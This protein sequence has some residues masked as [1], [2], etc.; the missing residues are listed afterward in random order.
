[1]KTRRN[2][3]ARL[4][5]A[6]TLLAMT[7]LAT[8]QSDPSRPPAAQVPDSGPY[9]NTVQLFDDSEQQQLLERRQQER[10]QLRRQLAD[11]AQ[12]IE[13][14]G[15]RIQ[16]VRSAHPDLA[17]VVGLGARTEA[18][19][20]ELLVDQ[21]LAV[22]TAPSLLESAPSAAGDTLMRQTRDADIYTQRMN[23]IA[24]LLEPL[25]MDR[26]L[27][28]VQS[29]SERRRVADLEAGL[30]AER[31]LSTKQKDTMVAILHEHERRQREQTQLTLLSRYSP[32]INFDQ[33]QQQR[34]RMLAE[35]NIFAN[36]RVAAR[37]EKAHRDLLER[38]A[39]EL[40]RE[41]SAAFA[42]QQR[43]N[44]AQLRNWAQ[45]QRSL[46]GIGPEQRLDRPE[47]AEPPGATTHTANLRL[48]I[49]LSVN[50][51]SVVKRLQISGG[52]TVSFDAPEGLVVDAR[53][54]LL[55]NDLTVVELK[56]HELGLEG[57]RRQIGQVA[58]RVHAA[59]PEGGL[60]RHLSGV[61]ELRSRQGYA[62][63]WSAAA[64]YE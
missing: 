42:E 57:Q 22:E 26:Y 37:K 14:R 23:E 54:Y 59:S 36:E 10:Q 8:G 18:R 2:G 7:S 38:L 51:A 60:S 9:T 50:R 53:P 24:A 25:Q 44:V 58:G 62:I 64:T 34:K 11:P 40:S 56:F 49:K 35:Y 19:L 4:I 47:F 52:E 15:E 28:Y 39:P 13:L 1:M 33:S 63:H 30:P 17:R 31:K 16:Q 55:A 6:C 41:Q 27:G 3:R 32:A 43:N 29:L 48:I 12:R 46:L 20:I 61:T 45:Q 21:G 5:A